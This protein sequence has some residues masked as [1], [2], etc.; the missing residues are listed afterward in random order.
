MLGPARLRVFG[1]RA[2]GIL[3]LVVDA[4]VEEAREDF[5]AL[6]GFHARE[7]ILGASL[8]EEGR[9]RERLVVHAERRPDPRVGLTHRVARDVRAVHHEANVA[10]RTGTFPDDAVRRFT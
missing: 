10:F 7:E 1:L 5:L 9:G 8:D 3:E 2:C 4:E 6:F